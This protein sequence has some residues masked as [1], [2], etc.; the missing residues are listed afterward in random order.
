MSQEDWKLL[1]KVRKCKII[2]N[3][4]YV[5]LNSYIKKRGN[6]LD[7]LSTAAL[8]KYLNTLKLSEDPRDFRSKFRKNDDTI[9]EDVCLS[10]DLSKSDKET[11]DVMQE[12]INDAVDKIQI[13]INNLHASLLYRHGKS[14]VDDDIQIR[15]NT[16]N[17]NG[18]EYI[19]Y[20][21]E[22][23]KII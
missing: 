18:I 10:F 12:I 8:S 16:V 2:S 6:V 7:V 21:T 19:Y 14:V 20:V 13:C 3:A 15:F 23:R 11:T 22:P 17:S 5:L 9:N 4:G 1:H